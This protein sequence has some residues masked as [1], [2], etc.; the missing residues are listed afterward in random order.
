MLVQHELLI[1]VKKMLLAG[2]K[3]QA[4]KLLRKEL[5]LSL[6][7]AMVEVDK[8]DRLTLS[9]MTV[10]VSKAASKQP[11]SNTQEM[12]FAIRRNPSGGS[13]YLTKQGDRFC[14]V[15]DDNSVFTGYE[16]VAV[17]VNAKGLGGD[18]KNNGLQI[19]P[20]VWED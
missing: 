2:Q 17:L 6:Q 19:I 9:E 3:I 13:R 11:V 7:D 4:I 16:A 20:V 10:A 14:D 5:R 18:V 12:L 15:L 1:S 8:L